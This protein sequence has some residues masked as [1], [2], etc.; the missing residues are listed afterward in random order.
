MNSPLMLFAQNSRNATDILKKSA[1]LFE[2]SNGVEA[3][4]SLK[5]SDP[6]TGGGTTVEG[7]LYNKGKKFF[8]ETPDTETWVD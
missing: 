4:I 5:E 8:I 7:T 1:A 2:K 6:T 3:R